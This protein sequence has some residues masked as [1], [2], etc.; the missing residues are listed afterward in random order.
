MQI[1][2]CRTTPS[3]V[4]LLLVNMLGLV[5]Q[6]V[7]VD[8]EARAAQNWNQP[9]NINVQRARKPWSTGYNE[10]PGQPVTGSHHPRRSDVCARLSC[11]CFTQEQEGERIQGTI[12]QSSLHCYRKS[13]LHPDLRPMANPLC[14]NRH[15]LRSRAL[16]KK[17]VLVRPSTNHFI[18]TMRNCNAES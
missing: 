2:T 15:A 10:F 5:S 6:W 4:W 9:W 7:R 18:A 16:R 12:T 8:C 1:K 17:I 14:N 13:F 3:I 11:S